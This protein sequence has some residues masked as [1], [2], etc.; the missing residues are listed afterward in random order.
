M[1]PFLIILGVVIVLALAVAGIYNR[2]VALRNRTDEAWADIDV[3]LKRRYDLIPN[4]VNTVKGYAAHESGVFQKVT[5]ARSTAMNAQGAAKQAEAENM[6]SGALKSLFAV[7]EAYPDLK[8]NENFLELQ[9][10]LS[11]TENKI[12]A[13]RR[14]YNANV[15]DFNTATQTFPSNIVANMFGFSN[16][17]FFELEEGSA[18]EEPVAVNF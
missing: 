5:E 17:E 15:R 8:A 9:R 18:A 7:S 3:Q 12:Q 4:L 13:A 11:D 6:L 2:F 16:R 10:E 1:L 14:F